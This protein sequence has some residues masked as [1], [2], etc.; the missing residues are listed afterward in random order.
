MSVSNTARQIRTLIEVDIEKT[1]RGGPRYDEP[2]IQRYRG[3]SRPPLND[4]GMTWLDQGVEFLDSDGEPLPTITTKGPSQGSCRST[5]SD[6][7]QKLNRYP[8]DDA[9]GKSLSDVVGLIATEPGAIRWIENGRSKEAREYG[10]A[11]SGACRMI[12]QGF[13]HIYPDV[14]IRV[15]VNTSEG[16]L[17]RPKTMEAYH[18]ERRVTAE[19]SYRRL[20][21][22]VEALE[23]SGL[24]R[25]RAVD[26]VMREGG[27]S[28]S[29]WRA[30]EA[31]KF[32][33]K[34]RHS[35]RGESA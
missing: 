33:R 14:E 30:Y 29:R 28:C 11:L 6:L 31:L 35:G 13:H 12:A 20:A 4:A 19:D 16:S 1:Q 2:Y 7:R 32:V 25:P 15:N 22:K 17:A 3:S 24:T 9:G 8:H 5:L 10:K 27:E 34:E 26:E 23:D 21:A 18:E